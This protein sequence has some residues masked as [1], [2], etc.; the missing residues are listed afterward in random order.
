LT[1]DLVRLLREDTPADSR[2]I[3]PYEADE[4]FGSVSCGGR[5]TPPQTRC[6]HRAI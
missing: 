5:F 1:I 4:K 2:R 6:L 3:V